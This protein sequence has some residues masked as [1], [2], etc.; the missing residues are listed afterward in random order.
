MIT[1]ANMLNSNTA[2]LVISL[3]LMAV[4]V[5][6]ARAVFPHQ[7]GV[8]FYHFWGIALVQRLGITAQDPYSAPQAYAQV[9]NTIADASTDQKLRDVNHHRRHIEPTATPLLYG[10]FAFLPDDYQHAQALFAFIQYLLAGFAI[11]LLARL[12]G[13]S[14]WPAMSLALLTELSFNPFVQDVNVGNVNSLQLAFLAVLLHVAVRKRYSGKVIVDALFVGGLGL[15][16]IFKPNTPWIALALAMHYWVV[17]GSRPFFIG[18]VMAAILGALAF[19][20]GAW[21]F[22]DSAVWLAWFDYARGMNNSALHY[23]FE[24]GNQSLAMLLADRTASHSAAGYGLLIAVSM[25]ACLVL[26]WLANGRGL[27]DLVR[28]TRTAFANAWFAASIGVLF[29]FATAPLVW[30]HYHLLALIPI[31]WLAGSEHRWP[32]GLLAA[33]VCYS[34]LSRPLINVLLAYEYYAALQLAMLFSWVLLLP[35]VFAYGAKGT[36]GALANN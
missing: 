4:L 5:A 26:T 30:P 20:I 31:I 28:R 16:V 15:F 35:G 34:A 2:G 19:G 25:L 9:L 18:L 17:R 3:V 32:I 23:S 7:L 12:R 13:V 22:S 24:Q 27:Y 6:Q 29:T 14:R 33:T 21:Y 10:F 8:D 36:Q 1:R 11:Y